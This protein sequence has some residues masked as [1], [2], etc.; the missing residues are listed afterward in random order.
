[1][2]VVLHHVWLSVWPAFPRNVGPWWV[3]WMLYGHLAV[4]V[5]I[6]VSGFSLSLAP[7]RR[8]GTLSGG[9]RRFLRRRAWRILPPYWMA[10]IFSTIITVLLL[11][12]AVGPAAVLRGF[13]VH[14]LLIQDAVGSFTPNGAFW[15]IAVEW[16]IYFV[17][18]L[19][20]WL[21]LKRSIPT[22]VYCTV[23]L[24]LVAHALAGLGSPLSKVDHLT[25]QFLALFALGVLAANSGF[26][27]RAATLRR[28]LAVGGTAILAGLVALALVK[29]SVWM[30]DQY[31]WVDLV[32]GAGIACLIAVLYG[33]GGVR[34]RRMF[35][36]RVA[37]R[38]GLFSYSIY[39]M[40]GPLVGVL[41]VDVLR[42]MHLAP[43]VT[44][45]LL[46]CIGVPL[47]L[48]VCYLFHLA[49]E[50]PFLER[51]DISALRSLPVVE[52]L[53]ARRRVGAAGSGAPAVET[54][55]ARESAFG[56]EP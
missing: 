45:A 28:P 30:V 29:G 40:H 35:S 12:P 38:I 48:G 39:L 43:L 10:L 9:A 25:P 21:G 17:F 52:K 46:L 26:T 56:L 49:F 33:G 37:R 23:A 8:G 47:I 4:A 14:A 13:A 11:P 5:F 32:F 27:G 51:R 31:F 54:L 18:P 20:L 44:F 50:A 22:A 36:S 3:G 34:A 55:T 19:I 53:R 7:M 15:S 1:M 42:P 41:D 2:F 24:V 16:Q 6:I